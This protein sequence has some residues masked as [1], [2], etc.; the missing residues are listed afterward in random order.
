MNTTVKRD[1]DFTGTMSVQDQHR[2]DSAAL[3]SYLHEHVEGFEG[4]LQLEEFKGGQSNPTYKLTAGS[5]RYV[6]RRKPPGTLLKSAHAVDREYK[7]ISALGNTDV[8]VSKTHCLCTDD[9]IIGSWFYVMDYVD[10]RIFWDLQ[11]PSVDKIERSSIYDS[12]ND[13][14]AKLH[15]VDY[16]AVGL[17]DFGKSTD[18]IARQINR[19]SK[20][21]HLS[22]TDD[23]PEMD[24]LI[25][26]LPKN[27]PSGDEACIV[28]GDYRLDNV[29]V[30]KSQPR[31]E[32]I[33]DWELS[34]IGHPLADFAYHCMSWLLVTDE[35]STLSNA[36][37]RA[38]GI[39]TVEEYVAKYCER[40][41]R[42]GI[43]NWDFYMAYNM[44]RIAAIIQGIRGRV[45]DGT[46]ASQA[47][48]EMTDRVT[49]MAKQGW[50][51]VEKLLG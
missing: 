35:F 32:A 36:Q 30:H 14:I 23:I 31:V 38:K 13:S 1:E 18:Y 48:G 10:G 17:A 19:W 4:G 8:P 9:S 20:Q 22:Q 25:E 15:N 40:T 2:V 50:A 37:R 34:T 7:V 44:F 6:M 29:M 27:I 43:E 5:K 42:D 12:L 39:P 51:Q 24:R 16:K 47:A 45:R 46:A 41:G 3:E 21:Y 11:I 49:P 33:L 28:H 26:W